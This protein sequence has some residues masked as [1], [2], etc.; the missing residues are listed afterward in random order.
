MILPDENA[1]EA[2]VVSGVNVYPV[3]D[4]R[5]AVELVAAL[6]S[7]DPPQPLKIDP[8]A[9]L[10]QSDHYSVDFR[11]VRGQLSAKRALEVSSPTSTES[12]A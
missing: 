4:L 9:I 6:R 2:G 5:A 8:S 12:T 11:E 10:K 7:A 1:K 3:A